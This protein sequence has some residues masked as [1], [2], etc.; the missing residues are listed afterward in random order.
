VWAAAAVGPVPENPVAALE[1]E[2]RAGWSDDRN[3]LGLAPATAPAP[4]IGLPRKRRTTRSGRQVLPKHLVQRDVVVVRQL[5][6]AI[7]A[8]AMLTTDRPHP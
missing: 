4:G 7:M 5:H 1:W 6:R 2:I 3:P 8:H